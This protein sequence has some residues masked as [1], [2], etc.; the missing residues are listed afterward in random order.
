MPR[1]PEKARNSTNPSARARTVSRNGRIA[2]RHARLTL[3]DAERQLYA[4]YLA[5]TFR[6]VRF[7][8]TEAHARGTAIQ[9]NYLTDKGG[10][11]AHP[12]GTF[13]V[14]YG[15][16]KNA[17]RDLDHDLLTL[18]AQGDYAGTKRMLETLAVIRPAMQK[19]LDGMKDIPTDID[20]TNE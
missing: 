9:F 15:K 17:V 1:P 6:S 20:P 12:D 2:G 13:A 10:F 8:L 19:A 3:P 4:T 11:V 7:G 14:D 18:E 5:S 16:I